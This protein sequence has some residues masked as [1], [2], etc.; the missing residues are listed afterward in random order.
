MTLCTQSYRCKMNSGVFLMMIPG[1]S[2][3][4]LSLFLRDLAP[5]QRHWLDCAGSCEEAP[6]AVPEQPSKPET[7]RGAAARRER[8]KYMT[9]RR[10]SRE[11]IKLSLKIEKHSKKS[12]YINI[13]SRDKN[14]KLGLTDRVD[15]WGKS[16]GEKRMKD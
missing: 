10:I 16:T 7:R 6:G 9:A 2:K 4:K 3:K 1:D 15:I 13:G 8:E 14:D 5:F 12:K 11:K